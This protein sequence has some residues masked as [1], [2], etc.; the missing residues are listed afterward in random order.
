MSQW[1][2]RG[3]RRLYLPALPRVPFAGRANAAVL[4]KRD[5]PRSL[6]GITEL[7][8]TSGRAVSV[9]DPVMSAPSVVVS[10]TPSGAPLTKLVIPV[11][12]QLSNTCR[13]SLFDQYW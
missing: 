1:F 13:L 8:V 5:S 9:G 2:V 11:S 3:P 6:L 7:P 10:P 12:C 4:K